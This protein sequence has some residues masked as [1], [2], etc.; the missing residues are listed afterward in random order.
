[1]HGRHLRVN[2]STGPPPFAAV[3]II[4]IPSRNSKFL[5]ENSFT[6]DDTS[7]HKLEEKSIHYSERI[8]CIHHIMR[9]K[10]KEYKIACKTCR[11]FISLIYALIYARNIRIICCK[12][13]ICVTS[14]LYNDHRQG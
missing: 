3:V 2:S 7:Y 8:H 10:E 12:M 1:M 9:S 14:L 13:L 5:K 4:T 6:T 11:Q